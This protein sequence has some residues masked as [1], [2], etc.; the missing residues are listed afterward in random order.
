M[1]MDVWCCA[2]TLE[3]LQTWVLVDWRGSWYSRV[4]LECH[5]GHSLEKSHFSLYQVYVW[6]W[7]R[8]FFGSY[9]DGDLIVCHIPFG[10]VFGP[11]TVTLKWF[12]SVGGPEGCHSRMAIWFD[13]LLYNGATAAA[14]FYR[15]YLHADV[16]Y[17]FWELFVLLLA[18]SNILVGWRS[19]CC[20]GLKT[21]SCYDILVKMI[22]TRLYVDCI[23]SFGFG[24]LPFS[25]LF[26]DNKSV[27]VWF[28]CFL[29]RVGRAL[30]GKT[31]NKMIRGKLGVLYCATKPAV[32]EV[33]CPTDVMMA[34]RNVIRVNVVGCLYSYEVTVRYYYGHHEPYLGRVCTFWAHVSLRFFILFN[35]KAAKAEDMLA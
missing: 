34:W 2:M 12:F 32:A 5:D 23:C 18:V 6:V 19:G 15:F 31:R 16:F 4:G 35:Q 11:C 28:C 25:W 8:A 13:Y 7:Y 29:H 27:R 20:G 26:T 21:K 30:S 17:V 3:G 9:R 1:E 22:W 14:E 10:T 24:L 33:A